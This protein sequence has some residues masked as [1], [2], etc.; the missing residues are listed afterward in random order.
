VLFNLL[1]NTA[2][3]YPDQIAF[4]SKSETVSY[5][6]LLKASL[7]LANLV[8]AR[9]LESGSSV[10]YFLPNG[11]AFMATV[12]A[13]AHQGLV[14][15]PLNVQYKES[16]LLTFIENAQ[17]KLLITNS[18]NSTLCKEIINKLKHQ[19]EL[20]VID[21]ALHFNGDQETT[22]DQ[23]P[24]SID[25]DFAALYQFS[26]GSTGTPKRVMRTHQQ[27][28][29]EADNFHETVKTSHEDRILAIAPFF[30]A[31]GFGNCVLA[32]V[33]VGATLVGG[34]S[35][36][37]RKKVIKTLL[38]EKVSIFPGVPFMF[39]ILA[40][41]PSITPI[42]LPDLRLA[43]SAGAQLGEFT[44]R[45]FEEKY[46]VQIKQLYG[47][48]ETGS[49]FINMDSTDGEK[50]QSV[51]KPMQ[52]VTFKILDE[53]GLECADNT[54]GEIVVKSNAATHGYADLAEVN[55]KTF[56]DGWYWTGD[57]GK[58]DSEGNLYITG[59]KKLFIN[60]AGNKVDPGEIEAKIMEHPKVEEVVVLGIKGK[61]GLE[62]IKAVI[63][64]KQACE[65]CEIREWC[66][67]KVADFKIPR[68][69]E[70]RDEI[71]KSPLGKVLR[72]YL[73]DNI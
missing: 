29:N 68:I 59:R 9:N 36:D 28:L 23:I 27:L 51:G 72:K 31:H 40:D 67:G 46:G 34:V 65:A 30:H 71:P 50:W 32:A 62:K 17:S 66:Q 70:F 10:A 64:S 35:L 38:E 61:Y 39:S 20:V 11:T 16:E 56:K 8:F 14:S 21:S 18:S 1:L 44:Y 73:I 12:F 45:N 33:K 4:Q 5:S 7:S 69:I 55:K 24:V 53:E 3:N 52:S 47:S 48:T 58:T 60:V 42:D 13:V 22:D 43:F 19:C 49:M 63:V 54:V 41:A 57:L 25:P 26:T 6:Q 15:V 2:C 37:R